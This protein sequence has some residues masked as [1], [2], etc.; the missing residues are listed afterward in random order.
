[1]LRRCVGWPPE[2][3][4]VTNHDSK[5]PV[6]SGQGA[7]HDTAQEDEVPT[8]N[9]R[10]ARERRLAR[11]PRST[12]RTG[13]ADR[14]AAYIPANPAAD[15]HLPL[16][17]A[18]AAKADPRNPADSAELLTAL[19]E[20]AA[21]RDARGETVDA[22]SL[23][24]PVNVQQWVLVGLAALTAGSSANYRSRIARVAAAVNGPLGLPAPLNTSAGVAM[25][26]RDECN[27]LL[28]WATDQPSELAAA[29]LVNAVCLLVPFG[30]ASA[31]TNLAR[32]GDLTRHVLNHHWSS[33]T[34]LYSLKVRGPRARTV[35]ADP[36]WNGLIANIILED[37]DAFFV[38]H[39]RIG[40]PGRNALS[41]LVDRCL[42]D[43][44]AGAVRLTPQRT[45]A[46]WI[47]R[48][49]A[50]GTRLDLL[51]AEAGLDSPASLGRYL[52]QIPRAIADEPN[53]AEGLPTADVLP[54]ATSTDGAL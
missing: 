27:R 29:D 9:S 8:V 23:L 25:Y 28:D 49:L 24:D 50:A 40:P 4:L 35:V 38:F 5:A 17:Q 44:G 54:A 22:E 41:N 16:I 20:H 18:L 36:A 2:R 15:R 52:Q 26:G 34:V 19:A 45:R 14:I 47:V 42:R 10:Q 37:A 7:T 39:D 33:P 32:S 46:T 1:M 43:S 31:E 11:S 48:H 51:L 30:L 3:P 53:L 6:P 13:A 21:W 12:D